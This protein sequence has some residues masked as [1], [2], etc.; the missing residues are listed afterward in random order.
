ML[1]LQVYGDHINLITEGLPPTTSASK[2]GGRLGDA[3]EFVRIMLQVNGP[4]PHT[5]M[6]SSSV[7]DSQLYS[8]NYCERDS[9]T[10]TAGR[11][12]FTT[13]HRSSSGPS[14]LVRKLFTDDMFTRP[15]TTTT[16]TSSSC[17]AMRP[18]LE[19][20]TTATEHNINN[21]NCSSSTPQLLRSPPPGFKADFD[22]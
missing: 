17:S 18:S 21:N 19:A 11:G 6:P 10:S 22:A 14:P 16:T 9:F 7:C 13:V 3:E 2:H 8:S 5:P 12:S 15:P 20:W 4:T 1:L